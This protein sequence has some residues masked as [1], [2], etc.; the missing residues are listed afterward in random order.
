VLAQLGLLLLI[1]VQLAL[2]SSLGEWLECLFF[3]IY[4]AAFA[5]ALRAFIGWRA[6]MEDALGGLGL[7][8]RYLQG[9]LRTEDRR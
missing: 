4:A 3:A 2:H 6:A 9:P 7:K 1:G 5:Y 8:L